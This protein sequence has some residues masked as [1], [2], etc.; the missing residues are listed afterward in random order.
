MI[1]QDVKP[2]RMELN[3]IRT[4]IALSETGYKLLKMKRD[5][6]MLEFFKIF[7][8]ARDIRSKIIQDYKKAE[9]KLNIARCIDGENEVNS[10]AFAISQEPKVV[11]GSKNV[12]GVVI[13]TTVESGTAKRRIDER[14]YG[15]IGIS[16][17]INESA[18]AY[19]QLV[20]DIIVAAEL[21]TALNRLV[22]EIKTTK[23]K[24]NAL[25]FKILPEL[26]ETEAFIRLRLEEIE[27][28]NIFRLKR[29]KINAK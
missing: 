19:E 15:V 29:I 8:K 2:T 24:V 10:A 9:E 17:R 12:M 11:M 22:D 1:Q 3:E 23:R 6:L 7:S 26:R 20:E 27:R 21:E 28:E 4:K 14:G 16:T 18:E 13:P 25:E 5:G